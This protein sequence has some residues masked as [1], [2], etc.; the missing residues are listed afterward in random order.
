VGFIEDS[1]FLQSKSFLNE[2]SITPDEGF[3]NSQFSANA[4]ERRA[5]SS[6]GTVEN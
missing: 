1:S 2:N 5:K 6:L 4:E 3:S